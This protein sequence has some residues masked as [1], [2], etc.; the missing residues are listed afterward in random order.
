MMIPVGPA[1]AEDVAEDVVED[2]AEDVAHERMR[3]VLGHQN[4][5]RKP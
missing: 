1:A 2:V 3:Q 5:L 4:L